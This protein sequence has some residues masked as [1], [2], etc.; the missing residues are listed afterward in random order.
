MLVVHLNRQ[1]LFGLLWEISNSLLIQFGFQQKE[2]G[3]SNQWFQFPLS[4][5]NNTY[6]LVT[7]IWY[8]SI[9][10]DISNLVTSRTTS[11]QTQFCT[12]FQGTKSYIAIGY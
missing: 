9:G 6:S 5:S 11:G 8:D 10:V 3:N 7:G 1:V 2:L 4:F 12:I